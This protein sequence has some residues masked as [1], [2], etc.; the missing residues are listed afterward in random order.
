[1]ALT[2][3]DYEITKEG[4]IINKLRGNI[5]KPKHNNRGYCY[6]RLGGKNY[7]IHR[8][9]AEKYIPNPEN[10]P[11]VN[12][13]DGNK[14]NNNVSNLEWSTAKENKIHAVENNLVAKGE[15]ISIHKLSEEDI[16]FI[17]Q[18]AKKTIKIKDLATMYNVS[19]K[20]ISNIV[21]NHTWNHIS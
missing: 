2:K 17:K 15:S 9:V 10:K 13:K 18:N 16:K 7:Y 1:M 6:V 21:N 14:D 5:L 11:Q 3:D 8:L 20:T 12:H 4:Y 19:L